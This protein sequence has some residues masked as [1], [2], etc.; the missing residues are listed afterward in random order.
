MESSVFKILEYHKITEMLISQAS[1]ILGKELAEKLKPCNDFSEVQSAMQETAEGC[2]VLQ[3]SYHVPLGGIRDIRK[4]LKKTTLGA[5]LETYELVDMVSTLYAMRNVKKFFK[6]M[7]LEV[8]I[9]QG[10]TQSIEILG[11]LEN[12]I[13]GIVDEHGNLRDDASVELKRIRR[14]IKTS[15]SRIKER[16][17]GVLRAAEY[18]KYFQETIITIRNERYVIPIKQEYRQFFPGIVHDQSASGATLFI[19]P[20]AIVTLNNDVKQLI[21][22]EK[23]EID[24]ILRMIS[25]Q[26]AKYAD[27]LNANC[28]LLGHIDFTFAK[29]KVAQTMHAVM[30]ELNQEGRVDLKQARHP[31]INVNYVVPIDIRLGKEYNTLL[32]TGPNT[33]G[34]TVSMKTLGLLALMTQSGLFIPVLSGSEMAVFGDEQSI[35][36]SLSTFSAHMTHI[37]NI[38]QKVEYD[39]LLLIDEIG[40]G[41]D[42]EEGAALAMAI[43][44]QLMSIGTKV[45]ATTHYSELKTFAYSKDGIENACVEFDINTLS[46]TYRLLIGIPGASNA[47]AISKRLGL[48]DS[49]IIRAKQLIDA[50]HAQFE[51]VLNTLEAE[52]IMYEQRNADIVERQRKVEQLERK[53]TELRSDLTKKKEKIILKA[54]EDSAALIRRTRR[55]ATQVIKELKEQFNDQGIQKRQAAIDAARNKIKEG[56][57]RTT[58]QVHKQHAFT[59]PISLQTVSAGDTVYITTL[60]QKGIVLSIHG[61][62]IAVQ[63]GSLKMNVAVANCMFVESAR[64]VDQ[65]SSSSQKKAKSMNFLK[66]TEVNREIDIRGMLVDDAREMVDKYLDDAILAGLSQVMII[67]GNGTGALRKGMQSYLQSHRSV[68]STA[69]GGLREGGTGVTIVELK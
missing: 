12:Q 20:M 49:L 58:T 1:S 43:L 69:M 26:I 8:P 45:L 10:W 62:S 23:Q 52:K 34:K 9:L 44:E 35:E 54:Q 16:L 4:L 40:A 64:Q 21:L 42:P 27:I 48:A 30:P 67:H 68:A 50:D 36:Q 32:I 31:L 19:E 5:V 55:E 38:L 66:T 18:Q 6:E 57:D 25:L 11:Q 14:E 53:M 51:K 7:E 65:K 22:A 46:P 24:R 17:D 13:S 56:L 60:D 61:K 47:F 33:G 41:T 63:L 39:D 28:D 37:V 2:A 15:Q 59:K 29:A 3:A